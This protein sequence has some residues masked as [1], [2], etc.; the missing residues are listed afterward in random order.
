MDDS[1]SAPVPDDPFFEDVA[2]QD[3]DIERY[4][5]MPISKVRQELR[6]HGINPATTI[7]VVNRMVTSALAAWKQTGGL[8]KQR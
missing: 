2:V 6:S 3:G 1:N 5:T 4:E 8:R 7:Q